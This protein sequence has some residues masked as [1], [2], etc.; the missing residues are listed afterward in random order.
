MPADLVAESNDEVG[1]DH[2]V[3]FFTIRSV[4]DAHESEVDDLGAYDGRHQAEKLP[5]TT[6]H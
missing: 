2:D 5:T 1:D 6:R 4:Y 3:I